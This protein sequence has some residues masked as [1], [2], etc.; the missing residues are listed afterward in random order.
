MF[1]YI[2]YNDKNIMLDSLLFLNWWTLSPFTIVLLFPMYLSKIKNYKLQILSMITYFFCFILPTELYTIIEDKGEFVGY[3]FLQEI[4][5]DLFYVFFDRKILQIFRYILYFVTILFYVFQLFTYSIEGEQEYTTIDNNVFKYPVKLNFPIILNIFIITTFT[6]SVTGNYSE[7]VGFFSDSDYNI[8]VDYFLLCLLMFQ[9]V[10]LVT[11][12]CSIYKN[13]SRIVNLNEET[14][15][16][17]LKSHFLQTRELCV[18]DLWNDLSTITIAGSFLCVIYLNI[19]VSII[20]LFL[21]FEYTR[22]YFLNFVLIYLISRVLQIVLIYLFDKLFIYICK[23][24]PKIVYVLDTY[25]VISSSLLPMRMQ[26]MFERLLIIVLYS[27]IQNLNFEYILG[28]KRISKNY[29]SM[30]LGLL[31]KEGDYIV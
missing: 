13:Y 14:V 30:V 25:F 21:T 10:I 19:V 27:P 11:V 24:Y 20:G 28:E 26:Q 8:R 17:M 2:H 7:I 22:S 15:S 9:P 18:Y 29:Y 12:V 6:C 16:L 31:K 5:N 1:N 3:L 4:D 23:K